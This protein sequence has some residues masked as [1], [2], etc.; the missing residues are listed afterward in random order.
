MKKQVLIAAASAAAIVATPAAFAPVSAA[1]VKVGYMQG[2]AGGRGIFG[3]Y[4][5]EGFELALDHLGGKLGGMD[6]EVIKKDTQ[7]KPDVGR[8]IMNE[9][10]KKDRVNFV[11]G[12]T[13]SNILAAVWRQA[14]RSK[15]YLISAN[16][17]WSGMDGKNCNPYFFRASWNNDMSPEAMGRLMREEGIDGVF[18]LSANYQAGKDMLAGFFA[19]AVTGAQTN[20]ANPPQRSLRSP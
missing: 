13:W 1:G 19:R 15:T 4:G 17:G 6:V 8:T 2:F 14:Y 12:I 10:I 7:H 20:S 3:R 16:A 5:F 11:A 18:E 9:F